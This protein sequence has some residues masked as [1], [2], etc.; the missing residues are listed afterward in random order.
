VELLLSLLFLLWGT[1]V[2]YYSDLFICS[3]TLSVFLVRSWRGRVDEFQY[4]SRPE[5]CTILGVYL[6]H[7]NTNSYYEVQGLGS[8]LHEILIRL[9]IA[10]PWNSHRKGWQ[11]A[12]IIS[13]TTNVLWEP[14]FWVTVVERTGEQQS[15]KGSV[16][17]ESL[18]SVDLFADVCEREDI[19]VFT[20]PNDQCSPVQRLRFTV[21]CCLMSWTMSNICDWISRFN[22]VVF[23]PF[24]FQDSKSS[25]SSRL[26][27]Q[28]QTVCCTFRQLLVVEG[29][30]SFRMRL[31]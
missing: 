5:L 23:K 3:R 14:I 13:V 22:C 31:D 26:C 17:S 19:L 8:C 29:V 12:I 11:T 4:S 1:C 30:P 27:A 28:R 9:C 24:H 7:A 10:T 20:I 15:E 2:E 18:L 21:R 6:L 25:C 16:S